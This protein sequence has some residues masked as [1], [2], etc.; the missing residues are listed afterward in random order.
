MFK[1]IRK[2]GKIAA[3]A[4]GIVAALTPLAAPPAALAD[5]LPTPELEKS[6]TVDVEGQDSSACFTDD[7]NYAIIAD[8][9]FDDNYNDDANDVC[10]GYSRLDLKSGEV[11]PIDIPKSCLSDVCSTSNGKYLYWLEDD[12]VI[13]YSVEDQQRVA[14][15]IQV[16]KSEVN[17]IELNEDGNSLTAYC[18]NGKYG[19][20]CVFN[21][22]SN[23]KSFTYKFEKDDLDAVLSR[24]GKRLYVCSNRKLKIIDIPDGSTSIKEIPGNAQCDWVTRAD[25]SDKLL[26]AT[27]S[28]DDDSLYTTYFMADYDGNNIDKVADGNKIHIYGWGKNI[29]ALTGEN[30]DTIVIDS[31]SGKQI[32]YVIRNDDEDSFDSISGISRNGDIA[33]TMVSACDSHD[34]SNAIRLIDTKTGQRVDCKIKSDDYSTPEF[35][36]SAQ[37]IIVDYS[38]AE[39]PTKMHIDVYK[40]NIHYS[41]IEKLIFFAQDNMPIVVDGGIAAVL[42]IIGGIAVVC[43]RRKKRAAAQT[44]IAGTA[45]KAKKHKRNRHKKYAQQEQVAQQSSADSAFDTQWQSSGEPLTDIPQQP[46]ASSAPKFCRH[47][48]TPLVPEAKFCPKCGHPVE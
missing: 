43:I 16:K 24:D 29:L 38:D 33:L 23:E 1:S 7:G 28:D 5:G 37:K 19:D 40:S 42:M 31:H 36:D 12:K 4:I 3:V 46:V 25:G 35:V 48:G 2:G 8:Y 10:Y 34:N 22:Q 30:Y 45:P 21:L 44:S 18:S 20:F 39:D 26:I 14:H 6:L 11:T 47:C 32:R 27:T 9:D 15:S 17:R 13:V 41:P